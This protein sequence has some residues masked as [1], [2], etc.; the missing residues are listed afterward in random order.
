M[1]S[2]DEIKHNQEPGS[3][4]PDHESSEEISFSEKKGKRIK[5]RIKRR[6]R[7]KKK[8]SFKKR[9]KKI[10]GYTAWVI[11]LA[12]FI[13]TLIVMIREL[14]IKDEDVRKKGPK[15]KKALLQPPPMASQM[16]SDTTIG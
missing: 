8:P 10:L 16:Y 9:L 5:K 14:E 7:I 1:N 13:I 2:K 6:I 15:K 11:I 3:D 4:L 12:G